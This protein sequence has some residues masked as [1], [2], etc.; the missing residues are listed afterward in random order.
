[1]KW[2]SGLGRAPV[3]TSARLCRWLARS[4]PTSFGLPHCRN[5]RNLGSRSSLPNAIDPTS[6][7]R[8]WHPSNM[9]KARRARTSQPWFPGAYGGAVSDTTPTIPARTAPISRGWP[10]G[11]RNWAR[12]WHRSG[13]AHRTARRRVRP[14]RG[15]G[16]HDRDPAEPGHR[17]DGQQHAGALVLTL[18]SLP[19]RSDRSRP[20]SSGENMAAGL[21][22]AKRGVRPD[23][24]HVIAIANRST[25]A[26]EQAGHPL[27]LGKRP[28]PRGSRPAIPSSGRCPQALTRPTMAIKARRPYEA[29]ERSG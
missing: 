27:L 1:M 24:D 12:G 29:N 8:R 11:G 10:A 28:G 20:G 7:S 3:L 19:K 26:A 9:V 13:A 16:E 25:I 2:R 21:I 6:C 18:H 23:R 4:S 5:R 15:S 22:Y 17:G 14:P